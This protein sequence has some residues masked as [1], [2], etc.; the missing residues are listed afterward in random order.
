MKW[1]Q[2]GGRELNYISFLSGGDIV[3]TPSMYIQY[4]IHNKAIVSYIQLNLIRLPY[5]RQSDAYYEYT[6]T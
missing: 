5:S 3:H 2:G 4:T 1:A 6:H